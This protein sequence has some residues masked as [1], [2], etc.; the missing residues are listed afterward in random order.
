MACVSRGLGLKWPSMRGPTSAISRVRP[1][2]SAAWPCYTYLGSCKRHPRAC[3]TWTDQAIL[4]DSDGSI[5]LVY[6]AKKTPL[7][8]HVSIPLRFVL[9]TKINPYLTNRRLHFLIKLVQLGER[10]YFAEQL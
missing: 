7:L 8:N 5:S 3:L 6:V 4:N 2:A 10:Q 1:R 9:R